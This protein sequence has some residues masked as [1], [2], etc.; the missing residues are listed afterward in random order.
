MTVC[1]FVPK[2]A[3]IGQVCETVD[4]YCVVSNEFLVFLLTFFGCV[5][6]LC[7]RSCFVAELSL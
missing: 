7:C 5:V 3:V 1:C 6:M 4:V 2:N